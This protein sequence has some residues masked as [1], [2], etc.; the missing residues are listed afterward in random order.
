NCDMSRVEE[1][2]NEHKKKLGERD[3]VMDRIAGD[4]V[5]W[6]KADGLTHVALGRYSETASIY[7]GD[8]SRCA[9]QLCS[10][11]LQLDNSP[12]GRAWYSALDT[13][14]PGKKNLVWRMLSLNNAEISQ[15][16]Q[17]AL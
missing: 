4:L 13:F 6:L 5:Q 12:K 16:M 2:N 17:A 7:S 14:T 15:E 3:A 11:L 9:G 10:I 1:F 8:G